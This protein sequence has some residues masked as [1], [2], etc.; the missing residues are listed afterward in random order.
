M[1]CKWTVQYHSGLHILLFVEVM[2]CSTEAHSVIL[3]NDLYM[4]SS[5]SSGFKNFAICGSDM[6]NTLYKLSVL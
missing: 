3:R 4:D 6:Y 5:V 1:I 2:I